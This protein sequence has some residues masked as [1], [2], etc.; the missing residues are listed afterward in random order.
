MVGRCMADCLKEFRV[1]AYATSGGKEFQSPIV[2]GE[3][4]M[5][6]TDYLVNSNVCYHSFFSLMDVYVV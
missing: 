5:Q 2:L 3:K 4:R 1:S 6:R